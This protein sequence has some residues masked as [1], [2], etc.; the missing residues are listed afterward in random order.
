MTRRTL[1]ELSQLAVLSSALSA[2]VAPAAFVGRA[3]DFASCSASVI[4]VLPILAIA[5][6]I[7]LALAD[8]VSSMRQ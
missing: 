3:A 7:A 5:V 4:G 8:I 2:L 6:F 1:Q